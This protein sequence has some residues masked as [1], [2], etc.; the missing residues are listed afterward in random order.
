MIWRGGVSKELQVHDISKLGEFDEHFQASA[1]AYSQSM[2]QMTDSLKNCLELVG[3]RLTLDV[4][5][6]VDFMGKMQVLSNLVAGNIVAMGQLC[7]YMGALAGLVDSWFMSGDKF[8]D[9][10]NK[11][12]APIN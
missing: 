3:G 8:L 6:E 1:E 4:D 10:M 11:V 9:N 2:L 7:Q 5:G 12:G